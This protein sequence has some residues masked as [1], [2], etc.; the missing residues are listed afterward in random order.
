MLTPSQPTRALTPALV[1]P[2]RWLEQ[3]YGSLTS[4]YMLNLN[5]VSGYTESDWIFLNV[6]RNLKLSHIDACKD[7]RGEDLL[8]SGVG[9]T[10]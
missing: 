10:F 9:H 4:C 8:N 7:T 2:A 5:V 1:P 3:V 6:G